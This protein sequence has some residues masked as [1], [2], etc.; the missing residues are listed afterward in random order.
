RRLSLLGDRGEGVRIG[1]GEIGQH[2][3]VEPDLRL[4]AAGDELVVR[5]PVLPR[6]GVD[7]QDPKAPELPLPVLPIAVGVGERVLDL[8]LRL[9][10]ARVLEAP[11]A[12]GLLEHLAALLARV[13]GSLHP[14]HRA[15]RAPAAS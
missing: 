8:L 3:A 7:A 13:D 2:L 14:R 10:V 1:Y 4:P 11:V 9:A 12:L 15:T 6:R 5:E